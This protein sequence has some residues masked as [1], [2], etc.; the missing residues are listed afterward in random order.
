MAKEIVYALVADDPRG[1]KGFY[2]SLRNIKEAA[3]ILGAPVPE[4][5]SNGNPLSD[6]VSCYRVGPDG[7]F[8]MKEPGQEVRE[9]FVQSLKQDV[10]A[11]L[12]K[13]GINVDELD[14]GGLLETLHRQEEAS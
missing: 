2:W 7:I 9:R 12:E 13:E 11:N 4:F 6:K 14:L 10:R 1:E 3:E 5:D 8:P